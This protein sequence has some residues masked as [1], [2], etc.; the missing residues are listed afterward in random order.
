METKIKR[1]RKP[2]SAK[3]EHNNIDSITLENSQQEEHNQLAPALAPAP[4]LAPALAP[5]LAPTKVKKPVVRKTNTKKETQKEKQK[6]IIPL[7]IDALLENNVPPITIP[8]SQQD[9]TANANPIPNLNPDK[10]IPKNL[11]YNT[12]ITQIYHISDLHIQLYK[13]HNEYQSVFNRV[14][15]YL[16]EEKVKYNVTP[17]NNTQSPLI[18]IV[19]GDILHSKS[20]LSPECIQITYNFI[21]TISS[22]MPLVLIPGNH[23]INM[24]NRD[25]LDSLTPI[26]ADLPTSYPIYYLIETGVYQMSNILFYHASI[27][28]YK[29]IHPNQVAI[30]HSPITSIMLYHGRVNGAVLFNGME[31]TETIPNQANSQANSQ[32]TP[33]LNN[34]TITPSTFE[35]YDMTLLGDIH[36]H[37]FLTPNIAYAGSLIQQNIGED[38]ANHGLIKWNIETRRGQLVQIPNAWSYVTMFIENKRANYL[39]TLPNGK[40]NPECTLSKNLRVRI[41]YKNTPESYMSDYI[42]LLKMNHNVLEYAW[43]NDDASI[44]LVDN[45]EPDTQSGNQ[46]TNTD[47]PIN[48]NNPNNPTKS[49]SLIDIA[50]PEVQNKYIVEY[51][52]QNEPNISAEEIE[53]I[54]KMNI[55][56]NTILK[57]SNTKYNNNVFNGHYKIKRLEFSNLFSFGSGNIIEFSE[58]KGIVGII[59]ANHLGKSSILDIII[60]TLFDEFTRKGSTKDIININKEDFNVRMDINI[61]QWMYTIIKTGTRTKVGASVRV[62][63]YRVHEVSKIIERLEEDNATKTKERIA[64]YFGCYEDIINTSFSIQHDNSC[65]IDSSNIKRKDE[66]ERIMRFEIVKK[67]Y[68]MANQKHNKDKAVYEHIKKKI[69]NDDI[70][71]IKKAKNKSVKLLDIIIAD[72]E[73][74]KTKIRFLHSNILETSKKLHLECNKFMEEHSE[75]IITKEKQSLLEKIATNSKKIDSLLEQIITSQSKIDI[76]RMKELLNEEENNNTMIIK[77]ANKKIKILDQSNEKLYKTRKPCNIKIPSSPSTSRLPNQFANQSSSPLEYLETQKEKYNTEV[78]DLT[79]QISNLTNDI[80]KLSKK[81]AEIEHNNRKILELQKQ[82]IQLSEELPKELPKELLILTE[83]F[84]EIEENYN[85]ALEEFILDLELIHPAVPKDMPSYKEFQEK[86]QQYFLALEIAKYKSNTLTRTRSTTT[87]TT[88]NTTANT[89]TNTNTTLTPSESILEQNKKL[90]EENSKL[91]E[92]LKQIKAIENQIKSLDIKKLASQNQINLILADIDNLEANSKID[93]EISQ[94]KEKRTKY[95]KRIEATEKLQLQIK[96]K[97]KN[98]NEYENLILIQLKLEMNLKSINEI[99]T[100]FEIYRQQIAEN[101]P[102]LETISNLKAELEEFEEVL[103]LIEDK[104]TFEQSNVSKYTALLLQV[105]RDLQ[106]ARDIESRLKISDLYKCALKQMPYILLSKIQPIL[107]KKVNDLLSITTD[108]TVKFDMSDSKIDIYLDR[109]IYKDKTRNIIIN[110]ASGFERFMASLAI[111]MALLELSNLPKI[112]FMAIDEGWSSFD[113]HNINNVS[114]ILDYLTSKFDFVLTISHL[115]QIKEHCDIQLSLKKDDNGFSR[116]V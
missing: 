82:Q 116:I 85:I 88:T 32:A 2:K 12:P 50:S 5:A 48:S 87:T 81:E 14:Y 40:H 83:N 66:L 67:L 103:D 45:Q 95:E 43:Q 102:I 90:E 71:E 39:C 1:G 23:D 57:E 105:K 9:P 24:N 113:T 20:D 31:F 8:T 27:F 107:E 16:K 47:N 13:R 64:E 94:N 78:I 84:P 108:F 10:I 52:K 100:K 17:E 56:Q 29:I 101:E 80:E 72:K 89:N 86:A 11:N 115:I 69:K 61:G 28:D 111:R 46:T 44:S 60:Y 33:Q 112:N 6:E 49:N 73:Y 19:T 7:S 55:S 51:L 18:V 74:A 15:E 79:T 62:E 41:L 54:K 53:E 97:C 68:E 21:K 38:I 99:L 63:F 26:I 96:N 76:S 109:S 4:V 92:E 35:P 37:Q 58:F 98:I 22:I 110:N 93:E 91:R 77:D 104:Y 106:E 114:V 70:V 30:T 42:T 34:K 3:E 59:A 75:I 65:F 25:R 36:K